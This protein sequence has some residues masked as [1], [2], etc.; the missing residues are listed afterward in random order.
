MRFPS[1]FECLLLAEIEIARDGDC[2]IEMESGGDGDSR[3]KLKIE[4]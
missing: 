2:G 4:M 1:L 3:G